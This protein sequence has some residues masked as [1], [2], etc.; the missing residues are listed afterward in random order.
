MSTN[1]QFNRPIV[2]NGSVGVNGS[3]PSTSNVMPLS[4][5][6]NAENYSPTGGSSLKGSYNNAGTLVSINSNQNVTSGNNTASLIDFG[7]YIPGGGNTNVFAGCVS[8]TSANGPGNFVIGQRT[9]TTSW[10]ET[11][12]IATSGNVGVGTSSPTYKLDVNGVVRTGNS[13]GNNV[14]AYTNLLISPLSGQTQTE[15]VLNPSPG[16]FKNFI[17]SAS[18]GGLALGGNGAIQ[19]QT[20][21]SGGAWSTAMT[22]TTSGSVGIGTAS[23]GYTLDV[24]G[25]LNAGSTN[26]Q[27]LTV[28]NSPTYRQYFT[29]STNDTVV[30][31]IPYTKTGGRWDAFSVE[32]IV[33]GIAGNSSGGQMAHYFFRGS[34][35]NSNNDCV[36][37]RKWSRGN[38][39]VFATVQCSNST[40]GNIV[41][42]T[43]GDDGYTQ[44]VSLGIQVIITANSGWGIGSGTLTTEV[45]TVTDNAL[46]SGYNVLAG[47]VGIGTTSPSYTL[48]VVGTSRLGS[49]STT[50]SVVIGAAVGSNSSLSLNPGYIFNGSAF[51]TQG[52]A[53]AFDLPGTGTI[54]FSD[55]IILNG[56]S[57]GIGTTSPSRMLSLSGP[58][59]SIASGPHLW[60]NTSDQTNPCFQML[61]WSGDNIS[62]NFDMYYDGAFRNSNSTTAWQIYKIANQ[63]QFK[64]QNGTAGSS[65]GQTNCMVLGSTGNVGI[66]I[67]SPATALHVKF[68]SGQYNGPLWENAASAGD[69]KAQLNNAA[70]GVTSVIGPNAWTYGG[71]SNGEL[72]FQVRSSAGYYYNYTWVGSG[73]TYFTGQHMCHSE[74]IQQ[75]EQSMENK[76]G[77]IVVSTGQY[78]MVDK[79]GKD[80]ITINDALPEIELS[81]AGYQKNVLGVVTDAPNERPYRRDDGSVVLDYEE[82]EYERSINGRIRVNAVGEGAIWVCNE[83]GNLENG[84]Y[85]TSSNVPGLGMKQINNADILCNYTVA[86]IT[87]SVDFEDETLNA[88]FQ[89]RY[90]Q[91]DGT[92]ITKEEY[93][94]MLSTGENVYVSVFAGCTYHCG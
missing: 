24:N 8:G 56:G 78:K 65:N 91:R 48:D 40:A 42:K 12:R 61:N 58:N 74:S 39:I 69:A 1:R 76:I 17:Y 28:I 92:I 32:V 30:I 60:I 81:A 64:Y 66:G 55:N 87:C 33:N 31:T 23:P 10:T 52:N 26:V 88:N 5:F 89:V 6:F 75:T 13:A 21:A 22:V 67:A 18:P 15:I 50:G 70:S 94:T 34:V 85:V 84:D 82:Y 29:A 77:Y 27:Y 54:S 63:L 86:K 73:T 47:N 3:T 16:P 37:V 25:S 49:I 2:F 9:G 71:Q 35:W 20:G 46:D 59:A 51:V 93:Q 19:F 44:N 7:A 53:F 68:S 41:I 90:L 80:A 43:N 38:C 57:L 62:M 14:T 4:V 72:R 11:L 45:S 36:V 83:N 79:V